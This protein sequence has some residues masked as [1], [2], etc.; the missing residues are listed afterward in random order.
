MRHADPANI[1]VTL[2]PIDQ[3]RI[4]QLRERTET[5]LPS[6]AIWYMH[7]VLTQCFLPYKD[8]QTD[9]WR[10]Q[11]GQFS[12]SLIAGDVKDPT[13]PEGLR[14]AGLPFGAKPRLF[15]SYI[16]TQ[17]IKQQSPFPITF[18]CGY[19]NGRM[20]YLPTAD[21]WAKGGY[22]VENSPFGPGAAECLQSEILA[23]LR[24]LRGQT[25]STANRR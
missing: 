25:F 24:R 4:A 12:I 5:P 18:M 11:N 19:T 14:V 17:A 16:N 1:V 2:R 7:T 20:A 3:R 21:E 8:P 10:R 23:V 22:E 13:T 6:E 9:R 15:Q